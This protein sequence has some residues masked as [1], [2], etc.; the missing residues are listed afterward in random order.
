MNRSIDSASSLASFVQNLNALHF[1]TAE[2]YILDTVIRPGK[3]RSEVTI[4]RLTIIPGQVVIDFL[5]E[6]VRLGASQ[7]GLKTT[8]GE[9]YAIFNA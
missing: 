6:A 3:L 8:T 5:R 7:S 4:S 2:D 9:L 1:N